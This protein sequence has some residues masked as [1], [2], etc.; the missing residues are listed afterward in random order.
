[1]YRSRKP[2]IPYGIRGF[3]SPLLC[4]SRKT[5]PPKEA[6]FFC[7]SSPRKP[8]VFRGRAINKKTSARVSGCAV[9]LDL[10]LPLSGS[11]Q[12]I[13]LAAGRVSPS[14]GC[15]PKTEGFQGASDQQK[16]KRPRERVRS[17]S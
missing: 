17:L 12:V 13:P 6:W 9:F 3:E 15:F 10:T 16:N 11:P 4:K 14:L 5:T 2:G 8:K 7:W 1:M